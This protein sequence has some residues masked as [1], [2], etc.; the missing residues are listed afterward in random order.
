[1]ILKWISAI[2]HR[3]DKW[4]IKRLKRENFKLRKQLM[5]EREK[6]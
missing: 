1:M 6:R 2:I 5:L 3:V 4:R